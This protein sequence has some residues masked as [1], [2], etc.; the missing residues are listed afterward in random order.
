MKFVLKMILLLAI[1]GVAYA[2][3]H[4]GTGVV[5]R[6]DVAKGVVALQHGPIK[7]LNWPGMT[8]DFRVREP[9]LLTGLKPEQKV[10][11]ELVEDKGGY[12]ITGIK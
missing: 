12:V 6:I 7:T 3:G 4:Q 8:M 5:K 11:F 1:A 10:S 9:K 2:Q